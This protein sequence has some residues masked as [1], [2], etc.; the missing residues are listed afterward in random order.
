ML[1]PPLCVERDEY[2]GGGKKSGTSSIGES[3][4]KK[5]IDSGFFLV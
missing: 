3:E 1:V 4:T 2:G 5:D